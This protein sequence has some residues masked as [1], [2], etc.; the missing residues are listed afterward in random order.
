MG[1]DFVLKYWTQYHCCNGVH[2]LV[3]QY[4]KIPI[5]TTAAI[6]IAP[7]LDTAHFVTQARCSTRPN[8]WLITDAPT[9]LMEPETTKGSGFFFRLSL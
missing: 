2:I 6:T 8:T 9:H 7:R 4:V 1:N 3:L 5:P